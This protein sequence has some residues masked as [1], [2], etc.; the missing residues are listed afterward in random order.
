MADDPTE[1]QQA[2]ER[3]NDCKAV[4]MAVE[5]VLEPFEG[6]TV[7]EGAVYHFVLSG[8]PTADMAYAWSPPIEDSTKRRFFA[9]LRAPLVNSAQSAVRVAIV[10]EH[11]ATG[12]EK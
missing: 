7:W 11:R 5:P 2:V 12:G 8:N 6:K 4:L 10:A 1:L 9:V 3:I